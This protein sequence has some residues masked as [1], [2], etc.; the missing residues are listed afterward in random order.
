MNNGTIETSPERLTGIAPRPTKSSSHQDE[1]ARLKH[2]LMRSEVRLAKAR[3]TVVGTEIDI[4]V[5]NAQLK[6][7]TQ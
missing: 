2:E 4:K 1:L 7:L 3:A 5:L 6:A